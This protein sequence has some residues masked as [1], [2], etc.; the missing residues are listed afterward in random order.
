ML[1]DSRI[2][3]YDYLY[4]LFYDVVT[5]NVYPMRVPKELT[6]SDTEE[7][8]IV[9]RVGGINDESEFSGQAYGS[10]RCYV[11]AYVPPVSRGRL[12]YDKYKE[13]EDGINAIIKLAAEDNQGEYNIEESS[14][15]S[16]DEAEI[17]NANNSYF[18]F[19]KSFVVNIIK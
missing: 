12:D 17:S 19:I 14:I 8:F 2:D 1:N 5:K 7:G 4:N 18:T 15:I 13:Y 11:Q 3:I 6:Q 9:I 10:A 16:T